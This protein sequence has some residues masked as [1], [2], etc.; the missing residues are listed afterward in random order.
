MYKLSIGIC[1]YNRVDIILNCVEA[2]LTSVSNSRFVI[3]EDVELIVVDNK[4]TDKTGEILKSS[5]YFSKGLFKY[6]FESNQGLS[7]ARNRFLDE[8]Q[9][10]LLL[11]LDDDAILCNGCVDAYIDAVTDN[12][13]VDFFGGMVC[14]ESFEGKPK[15]FDENFHMAYSILNLGSSVCK[16]P[17]KIGPIGANF[18]VRRKAITKIR[19]RT[20]LG[21]VGGSLLSG[22][23]TDFLIKSGYSHDNSL[24]VGNASVVHC[25]SRE[26]YTKTWAIQRF[27]LNGKSDWYMRTGLKG[28]LT[29]LLSQVYHALASVKSLNYFYIQCR[30]YSLIYFCISSIK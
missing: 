11:F 16:F 26:R 13:S 1:T 30:L 5:D 9:G 8:S 19:F 25:F 23:E 10:E 6:I 29:G 18:M 2:I 21:R 14:E 28:K 12:P 7:N 27:K 20:D 17:K 24:Y 15:W 4:S 3:G 22:E